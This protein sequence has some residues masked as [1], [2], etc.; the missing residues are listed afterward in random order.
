MRF[1]RPVCR[2]IRR[3]PATARH[4]LAT[5]H[6]IL[7]KSRAPLVDRVQNKSNTFWSRSDPEN[8]PDFIAKSGLKQE[9]TGCRTIFWA[10]R[11]QLC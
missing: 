6:T 3:R 10:A 1:G 11:V 9:D 2:R 7:D 4:T 8:D 5:F